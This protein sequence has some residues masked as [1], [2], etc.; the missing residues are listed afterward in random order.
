MDM[1]RI[2]YLDGGRL[3]TAPAGLAPQPGD[4]PSWWAGTV[5][6]L[7]GPFREDA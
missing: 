5:V 1:R 2:P 7:T 4:I 6:E 3:G